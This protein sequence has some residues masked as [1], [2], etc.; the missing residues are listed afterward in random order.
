MDALRIF[1][2][3]IGEKF[4]STGNAS[5]IIG[6]SHKISSFINNNT[7]LSN[8][9]KARGFKRV[10]K[11]TATRWYSN[12]N[13]LES[14][15]AVKEE[16]ISI[17][18]GSKDSE[19]VRLSIDEQFMV[20][21]S[22]ALSI[23]RPLANCIGVAESAD[24]SLGEAIKAILKFVKTLFD[25][26]WRYETAIKAV[27]AVLSYFNLDKISE[28]EMGIWLASYFMDRR[29]KMDYILYPGSEL[30]SMAV[31]KVATLTGYDSGLMDEVL[32]DQ[33]K[34]YTGQKG[35]LS[36]G[37]PK[38]MKSTE[39]W[40]QQYEH[41]MLKRAGLKLR[42]LRSS[43]ANIERLFSMVKNIQGLHHTR[44]DIDSSESLTRVKL[45]MAQQQNEDSGSDEEKQSQG[46]TSSFRRTSSRASTRNSSFAC[47]SFGSTTPASTSQSSHF[48]DDVLLHERLEQSVSSYY[49]WFLFIIDFSHTTIY[50]EEGV[51]LNRKPLQLI[52]TAF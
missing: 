15:M 2:N 25:S 27:E 34:R 35:T 41:S 32:I 40:Q 17:L 7:G 8:T 16:V 5:E 37:A 30:V 43:S 14:T 33:Y 1:L 47:S 4:S 10:T 51:N 23:L 6:W 24:T 21:N 49:K 50:M 12:V 9:L 44:F 3:L 28:D 20:K 46:Q 29:Y 52:L 39:W 18:D 26:N 42:N 38:E 22:S 31:A 19:P 11:A 13:M 45:S 48:G 36:R